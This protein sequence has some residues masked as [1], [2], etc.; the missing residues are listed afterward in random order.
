[1]GLKAPW[2][3]LGFFTLVLF[4][5]QDL[6]DLEID[7][8]WYRS[9]HHPELFWLYLFPRI[10]LAAL[11][12]GIFF[13]ISL[14]GL[15]SVPPQSDLFLFQQ[16]GT[17]RSIPYRTVRKVIAIF[18]FL[19]SIFIGD[20]F[21]APEWSYRLLSALKPVTSGDTDP[22]FH[23]DV[24]FYLFRLPL[25]EDLLGL[26][27][28]SLLFAAILSVTLGKMNNTWTLNKNVLSLS[29]RYRAR[30]FPLFGLIA[31]AL[32]MR[33]Q[34]SRYRLLFENGD[35]I[36]GPGYTI[37]HATMP[38]MVLLEILLLLVALTF[39][40]L[41]AEGL[42]MR[43]SPSACSLWS[44]HFSVFLSSP[45]WSNAL[46]YFPTS[47]TMRNRISE[48]IFSGPERPTALTGSQSNI[49]PVWTD[50]H[51]AISNPTVP[52]SGTFVSGTIVRF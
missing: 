33:V 20:H 24:T 44:L 23:H 34:L 30:V 48:K 14:A 38:A 43:L 26:L 51:K 19:V 39:F 2:I 45:P 41:F 32:A 29:P 46:S 21:T 16:G 49:F 12:A 1:M 4:S 31:I 6:M 35:L 37:M 42:P 27:V 50:W 15:F 25:L 47:F 17:V 9:V 5:T 3:F 11:S 36:S 7:Y 22:V 52:P 8:L 28:P 10:V 13:L 40:S 18:L